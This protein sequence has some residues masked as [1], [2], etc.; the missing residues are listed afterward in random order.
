MPRISSSQLRLPRHREVQQ[1]LWAWISSLAVHCTFLGLAYATG[2][3]FDSTT[4][5]VA[6]SSRSGTIVIRGAWSVPVPE[7]VVKV[8]PQE[9]DE[10]IVRVETRIEKQNLPEGAEY[11]AAR[12]FEEVPTRDHVTVAPSDTE[13]VRRHD[14]PEAPQQPEAEIAPPK[15]AKR[16]PASMELPRPSSIATLPSVSGTQ[17]QDAAWFTNNAPPSYPA[18][19]LTNRWSGTVW[20]RISIDESGTVTD[21]KIERSSGYPVLDSAA[22]EAVSRW[23]GTP[24]HREGEAVATVEIQ[25][26]IFLPRRS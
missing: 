1:A 10:E 12:P 17:S 7:T 19:A 8:A 24:A 3:W 13:L 15:K 20:L 11:V 4:R 21:V 25:P 23:R 2:E 18:V 26:I 14:L 22:I 6:L 5:R 16:E 9:P